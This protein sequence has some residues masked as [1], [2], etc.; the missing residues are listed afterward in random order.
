MLKC[1]LLWLVPWEL[2][3]LWG[4]TCTKQQKQ[5][6]NFKKPGTIDHRPEHGWFRKGSRDQLARHAHQ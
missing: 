3:I 1:L 2:C 4:H 5:N 6:F